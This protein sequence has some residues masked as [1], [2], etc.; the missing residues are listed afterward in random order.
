MIYISIYNE[1]QCNSLQHKICNYICELIII[2][3]LMH[4]HTDKLFN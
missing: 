1:T 2:F 3:E 4:H